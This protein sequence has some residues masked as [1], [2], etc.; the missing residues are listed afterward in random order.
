MVDKVREI[1]VFSTTA[2]E[3]IH[4]PRD[5]QIHINLVA[6]NGNSARVGFLCQFQLD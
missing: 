1:S 2:Q 4:F 6:N 5:G 3:K